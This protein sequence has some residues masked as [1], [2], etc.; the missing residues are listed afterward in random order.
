MSATVS[1]F[2]DLQ[3]GDD[4]TRV[5]TYTGD[6]DLTAAQIT[7][8]WRDL[9]GGVIFTRKNL[10]AGGAANQIAMTTPAS[11]IFTVYIVPA[12]TSGLL[13]PPGGSQ[14]LRYDVQI[15]TAAGLV[16]TV[17]TGTHRILADETI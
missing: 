4:Y 11:G 13:L 15:T 16:H 5:F 14:T 7:A 6:G 10:A 8:T 3:R 2:P 12:N 17:F 1:N 9:G